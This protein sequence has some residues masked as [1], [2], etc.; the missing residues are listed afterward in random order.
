MSLS[1]DLH[2]YIRQHKEAILQA[3]NNIQ[4]SP[5][6]NTMTILALA[7]ALF[8]PSGLY[9]T[10][11]SA[12]QLFD[13]WDARQIN[14]FMKL[15]TSNE[16][17]KT[18]AKELRLTPEIAKLKVVDREQSLRNFRE[19]SGLADV[20]DLLNENPLPAVLVILPA[21]SVN[22]PSS[23]KALS[24][25]ISNYNEVEEVQLDKD[26]LA[27]LYAMLTSLK[28][29]TFILALI[30]GVMVILVINIGLRLDI[31]RRQ[32][33]IEVTKL[34]GGDARFIQRPLLYNALIFGVLGALTALIAIKLV[35]MSL[36]P[37][38]DRISSLY[39]QSIQLQIPSSFLLDLMM[40]AVILSLSTAWVTLK[41]L[42]KRIEPN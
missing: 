37:S 5:L 9:L 30:F 35:F 32:Q 13:G 38:L 31:L 23:L 2:A 24:D 7:I 25:K 36:Q 41:L 15:D 12:N 1:Q 29:F 14:A 34:V 27:K 26:W 10:T 20:L 6:S 11:H 17:L 18:I 42:L 19:T 40:I 39:D 33:E 28:R 21:D 16:R 22:Q 8:L 4:A 3:L